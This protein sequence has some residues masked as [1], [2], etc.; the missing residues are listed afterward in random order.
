M[1]LVLASCPARD[2]L[3]LGTWCA[4]SIL[5][6]AARKR[7]T[8]A[9]QRAVEYHDEYGVQL[10]LGGLDR[11]EVSGAVSGVLDCGGVVVAMSLAGF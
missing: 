5:P 2:L 1:A 6:P 8:T 9:P 11:I 3:A 7:S 4:I 10:N